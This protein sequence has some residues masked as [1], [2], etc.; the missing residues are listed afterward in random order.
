MKRRNKKLHWAMKYNENQ[1]ATNISRQ[2][3][4]QVYIIILEKLNHLSNITEENVSEIFL[5]KTRLP[6]EN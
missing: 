4:V 3:L 5:M 1:K 2:K 6:S